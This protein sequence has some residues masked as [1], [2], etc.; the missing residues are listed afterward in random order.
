MT[1][2]LNYF[3]VAPKLGIEVDIKIDLEKT[4]DI[5]YECPKT[6]GVFSHRDHF[7]KDTPCMYTIEVD[8]RI[9]L[10]KSDI[11]PKTRG[12]F[13]HRDP[14]GKDTPLSVHHILILLE[15]DTSV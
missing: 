1:L 9:D 13:S 3:N 2:D 10:E 15:K 7:G 4:S 8:I 11:G 14:F 12:V 5:C 6:G